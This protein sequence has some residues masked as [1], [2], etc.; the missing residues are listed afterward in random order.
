MIYLIYLSGVWNFSIAAYRLLSLDA[1]VPM[2]EK[3]HKVPTFASSQA[4]LPNSMMQLNIHATH[5][6]PNGASRLV[7]AMSAWPVKT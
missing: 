4:L 1:V 7:Q 3:R 6:A 2:Q 5:R